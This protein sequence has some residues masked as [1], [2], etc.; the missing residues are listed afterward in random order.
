MGV[1]SSTL[2]VPLVHGRWTTWSLPS[3][4]SNTESARRRA[5]DAIA[6]VA[7]NGKATVV[8][9]A[10]HGTLSAFDV[11]TGSSDRLLHR[12]D[13]ATGLP[14]GTAMYG[15]SDYIWDVLTSHVDD[16]PIAVSAGRDRTI[17]VWD[18]TAGSQLGEP[19]REHATSPPA[20]YAVTG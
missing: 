18:L 16:R 17:R 12:W 4:N 10:R 20:R 14:I 13:L 1:V 6:L 2:P 3:D 8:A 19:F 11:A 15:H 7:V 9:G 5:V